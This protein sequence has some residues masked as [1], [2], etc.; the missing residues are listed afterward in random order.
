MLALNLEQQLQANRVGST[1]ARDMERNKATVLLKKR[2]A[3]FEFDCSLM[4]IRSYKLPKDSGSSSGDGLVEQAR[5][6][7]IQALPK[8]R[9]EKQDQAQNLLA[10]FQSFQNGSPLATA[11]AKIERQIQ[12]L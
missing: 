9:N 3:P 11:T 4:P 12:A 1:K 6:L 2:A 8:F 10:Q 7:L 5:Q